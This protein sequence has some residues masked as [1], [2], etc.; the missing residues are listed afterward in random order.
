MT[1]LR[2]YWNGLCALGII[3]AAI[4]LLA[5]TAI[6]WLPAYGLSLLFLKAVK[7]WG[8]A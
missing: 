6:I 8:R 7:K 5:Y 1:R 2:R 4:V 3:L